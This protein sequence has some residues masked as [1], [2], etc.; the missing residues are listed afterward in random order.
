AN[1][2]SLDREY[3]R[4]TLRASLLA[5]LASNQG[6]SAGPFRLFEAGRV[7]QRRNGDLPEE[8]E[9][10]AVVLAGLRHEPSWLEDESLLD[11][12]D[13]KGV[14]ESIMA[15]L[16]VDVT[17]EPVDEPGFHPGRC[18]V[19]KSGESVLGLVGEIHPTVKDR[20][21]LEQPQVAA[22]E[23][24]LGPVLA[25]LPQSLRQFEPLPRYP[26]ATRDLALIVPS[27][28]TAGRVTQLIMRHRGVG[29]AE[30]FDIYAGENIDSGTKSLAFHVYFQ[31]RDRTLT[32]E[33]VNRSLDGL[34]K[35]LERELKVT[36][37]A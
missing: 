11:F 27:D 30:L 16:A 17:Y 13:A 33:E 36:L 1:P 10:V 29:H 2:M 26:S 7:F 22:F 4:T 6:H 37:R 3:L 19:V 14:V 31:A 25:A 8:Q 28:V 24:Y 34:L 9:T 15:R 20:L 23:L 5:N 18:A 32:N 35:T 21:G 12:Y